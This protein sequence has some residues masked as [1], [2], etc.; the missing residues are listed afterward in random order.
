MEWERIPRP[1]SI[2]LNFFLKIIPGRSAVQ[3]NSFD[4]DHSEPP[5]EGELLADLAA[6]HCGLPDQERRQEQRAQTSRLPGRSEGPEGRTSG[7][8]HPHQTRGRVAAQSSSLRT[9]NKTKK[10]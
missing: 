5:E 6:R 4:A 3:R 2:F 8:D 9:Q 1:N 7:E 10:K